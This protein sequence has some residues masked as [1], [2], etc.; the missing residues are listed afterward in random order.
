MS[1]QTQCDLI[2]RFHWVSIGC[3]KG[4]RTIEL[5]KRLLFKLDADFIFEAHTKGTV[6]C[7]VMAE[8]KD[9]PALYEVSIDTPH[10]WV[11]PGDWYKA[12]GPVITDR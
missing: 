6:D 11:N 8:E 9:G 2:D 5:S 12:P 4:D 7:F 1:F 10:A 3:R